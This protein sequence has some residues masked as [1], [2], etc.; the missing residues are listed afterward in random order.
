MSGGEEV[1]RPAGFEPATFRSGGE[2]SGTAPAPEPGGQEPPPCR[3]R[4]VGVPCTL[5]ERH[6][7]EHR[8]RCAGPS[9]PGLPYPASLRRHPVTCAR[10]A[11]REVRRA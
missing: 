4:A 8:Y 5:K 11:P 1:V 6:K 10:P 2:R 3:A 7:G 9:C